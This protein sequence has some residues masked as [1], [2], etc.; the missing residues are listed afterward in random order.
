[1]VRLPSDNLIIRDFVEGGS[2]L[3]YR[4]PSKGVNFRLAKL[5]AVRAD[6]GHLIRQNEPT[7][8]NTSKTLDVEGQ[9]SHPS[10][11]T[12]IAVISNSHFLTVFSGKFAPPYRLGTANRLVRGGTLFA[13]A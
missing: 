12:R 3:G 5:G 1:M 7:V 13:V 4:L 2:I 8:G 10:T 6:E 11:S 9:N